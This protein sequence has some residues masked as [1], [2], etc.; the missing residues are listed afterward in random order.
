MQ[1]SGRLVAGS[2]RK[3]GDSRMQVGVRLGKGPIGGGFWWL[4]GVD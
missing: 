2:R 1:S 4:E 3:E